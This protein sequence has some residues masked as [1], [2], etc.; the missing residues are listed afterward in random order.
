MTLLKPNQRDARGSA[1]FTPATPNPD[2]LDSVF[3]FKD[4]KE[5]QNMPVKRVVQSDIKIVKSPFQ[6]RKKKDHV[7]SD[8]S[9]VSI[10]SAV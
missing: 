10:P 1:I 4:E 2:R 6:R 8:V 5:Q 3:T 9:V 7:E